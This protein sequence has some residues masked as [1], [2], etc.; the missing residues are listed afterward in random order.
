MDGKPVVSKFEI[1]QNTYFK[2][3]FIMLGLSVVL[4]ALG[5]YLSQVVVAAPVF[6]VYLTL[7]MLY[8]HYVHFGYG[9][10]SLIYFYSKVKNKISNVKAVKT[11]VSIL[12]S[13]ISYIIIY[14]A[15]ILL[16]FSQCADA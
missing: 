6:I 3:T 9:I 2:L 15:V 12:L 1:Y 13:P 5:I 16:V 7:F 4:A 11:I 10:I 8:Y 14:F